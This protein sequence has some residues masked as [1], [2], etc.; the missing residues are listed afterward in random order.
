MKE[1]YFRFATFVFF[2]LFVISCAS[3]GS[4]SGGP[5]DI[6]PPRLEISSPIENALNV[7]QNRIEIKF[8]EDRKSVV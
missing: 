6:T 8:N 5:K 1:V 7:S 2:V 3:V 4:P